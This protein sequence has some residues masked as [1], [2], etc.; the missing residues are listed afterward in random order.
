MAKNFEDL[1]KSIEEEKQERIKKEQE[2]K[3]K[4]RKKILIRS[5]IGAVALIGSI[6]FATTPRTLDEGEIGIV[7]EFGKI[8]KIEREAGIKFVK[9]FIGR[10]TKMDIRT[11]VKS[12]DMEASSKDE[13]KVIAKVSYNYHLDFN[14]VEALYREVGADWERILLEDSN[15]VLQ[16]F[17]NEAVKYNVESILTN[18]EKISQDTQK[19]INDKLAKYGIVIDSFN[20]ANLDFSKEYNAAIEKKQIAEQEAK[21]AIQQK[22]KIKTE[23]EAKVEAAKGEAEANKILTE[24]LSDR[25]I[26]LERIKAQLKAIEK[27]NGILPNVTG[28][29]AIPFIQADNQE[30]KTNTKK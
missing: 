8:K 22:E 23:A 2:Q 10:M 25:I 28:E 12:A 17:K 24:N 21:T 7:T 18:R 1:K 29:N 6:T 9:P 3:D 16:C 27:W 11:K 13:Q 26:E 15:I 4:K 5:S 14:K 19:A 20:A 30:G